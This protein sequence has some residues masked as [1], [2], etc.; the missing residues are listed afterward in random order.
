MFVG[1]S[2]AFSDF[3]TFYII[4]IVDMSLPFSLML[5]RTLDLAK[6]N[7]LSEGREFS[8]NSSSALNGHR[9]SHPRCISS[10]IVEIPYQEM[11]S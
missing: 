10:F 2:R 9:L 11:G 1:G 8:S 3:L 7:P 5:S 6:E 4:L